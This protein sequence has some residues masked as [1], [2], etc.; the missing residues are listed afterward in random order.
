MSWVQVPP[1]FHKEAVAQLAERVC[2]K[3]CLVLVP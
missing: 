3:L 1:A 2:E